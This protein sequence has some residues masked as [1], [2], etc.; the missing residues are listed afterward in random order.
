M[1]KSTDKRKFTV[2]VHQENLEAIESLLK[3][4]DKTRSGIINE[5]LGIFFRTSF[6]H[7]G[8]EDKLNF[9]PIKVALPDVL[10][11]L[12]EKMYNR[13]GAV[14]TELFVTQALYNALMNNGLSRFGGS[15]EDVENEMQ[16]LNEKFFGGN[17]PSN[18]PNDEKCG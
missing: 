3:F 2:L 15:K 4:S 18:T 12:L 7:T 9:K 16:K 5:A 17:T 8:V 13:F 1:S 10:A 14:D 11:D 6:K